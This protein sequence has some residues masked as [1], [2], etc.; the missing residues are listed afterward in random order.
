MQ[1][2]IVQLL[3]MG[4]LAGCSQPWNDPYPAA[5]AESSVLYAAFTDRPKHLDPAQSYTEDE[6][7]FTCLL[8]TSPS[9][10]D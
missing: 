1:K 8:Y 5:D 2:K 9:P 10:R 7:T 3:L 6:I 4:T